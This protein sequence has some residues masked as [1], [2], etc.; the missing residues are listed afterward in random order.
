MKQHDFK[1]STQWRLGQ[2]LVLLL[3][4]ALGSMAWLEMNHLW[5]QTRSGLGESLI[6]RKYARLPGGDLRVASEPSQGA[7]FTLLL[8]ITLQV[9]TSHLQVAAN[10]CPRKGEI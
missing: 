7:A 3:V 8:P 2:G 4:V 1:I 9:A 10:P 6:S 5:K